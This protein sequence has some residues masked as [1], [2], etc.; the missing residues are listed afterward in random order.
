[1]NILLYTSDNEY[2]IKA[3]KFLIQSRVNLLGVV[4]SDSDKKVRNLCSEFKI[5][6]YNVNEIKE[7]LNKTEATQTKNS[8]LIS[9]LNTSIISKEFISLFGRNCINF[10]PSPL[11]E[12]RGVAG[13]CYSILEGYKYW[14][15]T[16]HQL[17]EKIDAGD[18]I[19]KMTFEIE[20]DKMFASDVYRM[21][22]AK[23]FELFKIVMTKIV[24]GEKLEYQ[25]QSKLTR[26]RTRAELEKVKQFSANDTKE[27]I[28][29]KI[30]AFWLPP[31]HGLSISINNTNYTLVNVDI[32]K[33]LYKVYNNLK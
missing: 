32:L 12:H 27:I 1:M 26:L 30:R 13:C 18:I 19:H 3:I 23:M 15:V 31:Y 25:K 28:E 8:F 9:Y 16:A 10:H 21:T 6:I 5:P 29:R 20:P 4:C 17:I 11:P 2:S 33:E 22:Q 14:G 7:K 24:N